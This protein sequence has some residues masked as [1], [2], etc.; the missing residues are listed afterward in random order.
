MPHTDSK[1]PVTDAR[2]HNGPGGRSPGLVNVHDSE[3]SIYLLPPRKECRGRGDRPGI[4]RDHA[5]F[6]P[7]LQSRDRASLQVLSPPASKNRPR[8][9]ARRDDA[10]MSAGRDR[11][12][13]VFLLMIYSEFAIAGGAA[14][15]LASARH[16]VNPSMLHIYTYNTHVPALRT[17]HSRLEFSPCAVCS[18]DRRHRASLCHAMLANGTQV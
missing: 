14:R 17:A 12:T 6:I 16:G 9:P 13:I 7:R 3:I 5:K 8:P 10:N 2:P 1:R 4:R 15:W 11:D 18:K